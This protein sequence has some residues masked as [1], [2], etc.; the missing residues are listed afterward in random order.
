MNTKKLRNFSTETTKNSTRQNDNHLNRQTCAATN[1]GSPNDA[2]WYVVGMVATET[3]HTSSKCTQLPQTHPNVKLW[4][5]CQHSRTGPE[6]GIAHSNRSTFLRRL[7]TP[8]TLLWNDTSWTM[9]LAVANQDILQTNCATTRKS[10][11][12]ACLIAFTM[13]HLLYLPINCT[14]EE[15]PISKMIKFPDDMVCADG[16][17]NKDRVKAERLVGHRVGFCRQWCRANDE[18]EGEVVVNFPVMVSWLSVLATTVWPSSRLSYD[19]ARTPMSWDVFL[20][21]CRVRFRNGCQGGWAHCGDP[22]PLFWW[23]STDVHARGARCAVCWKFTTPCGW[24]VG[25]RACWR[26]AWRWDWRPL[27][28]TATLWDLVTSWSSAALACLLSQVSCERSCSNRIALWKRRLA[29]LM[30]LECGSF[31]LASVVLGMDAFCANG[32][33]FFRLCWIFWLAFSVCMNWWIL[34]SVATPRENSG[35]DNDQLMDKFN[36][37]LPLVVC[38]G[39]SNH[40]SH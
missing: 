21:L 17:W 13:Q 12:G 4:S 16:T 34:S 15:V 33:L 6:M 27:E 9:S 35:T 37:D 38:R 20:D 19:K 2:P 14:L 28:R 32:W 30:C 5:S 29:S 40:R 25:I 39:L 36:L 26:E 23:C 11:Q 24:V 18:V 22:K 1:S 3:L 31:C 7:W 8:Y 10:D